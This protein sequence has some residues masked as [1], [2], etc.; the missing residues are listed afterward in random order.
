MP[1]KRK[2]DGTA[3]A[4]SKKSRTNIFAGMP[5]E[6]EETLNPEPEDY[7][8]LTKD[9]IIQKLR[10]MA[11]YARSLEETIAASKPKELSGAELEAAVDKVSDVINR[12]IKKQMS[13]RSILKVFF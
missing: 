2:S 1:P 4:A 8:D 10:T 5:A 7:E 11:E 12:G 3:G 6:V 13:V 9:E